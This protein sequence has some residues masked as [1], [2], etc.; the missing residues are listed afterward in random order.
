[1]NQRPVT[2]QEVVLVFLGLALIGGLIL[3]WMPD[4]EPGVRE[5]GKWILAIVIPLM[6]VVGVSEYRRLYRKDLF[7]DVLATLVPPEQIFQAGDAHF[8]IT[9][10]QEGEALRLVCLV[11]NLY[12]SENHFR[13][14]LRPESGGDW[15][16]YELPELLITLPA[17]AVT[18]AKLHMPLRLADKHGALKLLIS[19]KS[20]A[21]RGRQVRFARRNAI[22]MRVHSGVKLALLFTGHVV[23]GGGA[24]LTIPLGGYFQSRIAEHDYAPAVWETA[25]IW[26]PGAVEEAK[27]ASYR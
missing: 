9:G 13:L 23:H 21:S 20:K 15:L 2:W 10:D 3:A 12:D 19:A 25:V 27:R 7:P 18:Q 24:F 17:G 22:T 8:A 16:A 26:Q 4:I 6:I 5:I 14:T 1:M 11:Q